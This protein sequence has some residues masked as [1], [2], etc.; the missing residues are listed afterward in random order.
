[1]FAYG[2]LTQNDVAFQFEKKRMENNENKLEK[3]TLFARE[4]IQ[5]KQNLWNCQFFPLF[6]YLFRVF[7]AQRIYDL[8]FTV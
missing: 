8:V 3:F 6:F 1:M 5:A 2:H 7:F 4:L